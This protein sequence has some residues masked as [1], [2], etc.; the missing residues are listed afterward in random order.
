[1]YAM[2]CWMAKVNP[3]AISFH[4]FI[5]QAA[6]FF[7]QRQHDEGLKYIF[8]LYDTEKKGQL[9]FEKFTFVCEDLGV[10]LSKSQML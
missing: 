3:E 5:K 6:Y 1:M 2:V 7:S 10:Y 9:D 8:E 4:E